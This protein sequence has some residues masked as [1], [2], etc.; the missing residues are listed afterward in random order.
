MENNALL[1]AQPLAGI[2]ILETPVNRLFL[3]QDSDMKGIYQ[4]FQI[5]QSVLSMDAL[6]SRVQEHM[7]VKSKALQTFVKNL[8]APCCVSLKFWVFVKEIAINCKRCL[9]K[10]PE[11]VHKNSSICGFQ[12]E[13]LK[14][15]SRSKPA[16]I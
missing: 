8:G 9:T 2:M 11:I 1:F 7:S 15:G 14:C 10:H 13:G 16:W 12:V 4:I 5:T 6:I 3:T